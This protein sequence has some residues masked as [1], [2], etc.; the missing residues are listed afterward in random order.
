MG[1]RCGPKKTN[2]QKTDF[3]LSR[4][5]YSSKAKRLIRILRHEKDT[6]RELRELRETIT[7]TGSFVCLAGRR[8]RKGGPRSL[9]KVTTSQLTT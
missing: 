4:G 1:H 8:R 7:N 3:L 9:L 6:H 2:K 5:L